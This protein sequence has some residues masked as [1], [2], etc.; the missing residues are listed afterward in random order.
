MKNADVLLSRLTSI[1]LTLMVS[2]YLLY[3]GFGGYIDIT[4]Q[5]WRL[6]LVLSG[7]YLG[8]SVLLRLELAAVGGGRLSGPKTVWC[9]MSLPEKMI[10][11]YWA[12]SGV[13]T[14][15][16]VDR[17]TALLGGGRYEGFLTLSLYC[18]CFL[19]VARYGKPSAWLLEVF[20]SAVSINCVLALIQLAG[21]NPLGLYPPGMSYYDANIRYAG[22][23][24]GTIGNVD[25]QSALLSIAIP[26]F[27]IGLWKLPGQRRLFLLPP[28]GLA[29]T[30]LF[31]SSVAGG[32]VGILGSAVLSV[33]VLMRTRRAKALAAAV[34]CCLCVASGLV[35]YNLGGETEGTI[36]EASEL[37]H[38]RWDDS[39]GS[40][41]LYIWRSALDLIPERPL[42]GGGPDTF[43]LRTEA[44]FE[45]YDEDLGFTIHSSV[46]V[47]HNEYLN[48][49][50]NQGFFALTFYLAALMSVFWKW[51]RSASVV[52]AAAVCGGGALGYCVQAFFGISSPI[53]APYF[54]LTFALL[55]AVLVSAAQKTKEKD[56]ERSYL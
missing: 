33:P 12:C 19:L 25:I 40:G 36:R 16:S 28:L 41:R 3:P 21:Y 46:D 8:G 20:A 37:M 42:I 35:V 43:G 13:S 39:F 52:P 1:Y 47:A 15:L 2:V 55:L 7:C 45:R 23:F 56:A 27:W 17:G 34:M 51:V 4:A 48:I 29:M 53:T 24:L 32:I 11:G 9:R 31:W 26:F 54:W 49:L 22:Q 14:A 18:G 10:I 6:F 30:V 5:K 44:S 50:V 38:G